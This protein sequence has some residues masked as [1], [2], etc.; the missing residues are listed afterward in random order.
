MED[1]FNAHPG[2]QQLIRKGSPKR[3][4]NSVPI[5]HLR[6]SDTVLFT[7]SV[8]WPKLHREGGSAKPDIFPEVN[9]LSIAYLPSITK[10]HIFTC[11]KHPLPEFRRVGGFASKNVWG[12][13]YIFLINN[14]PPNVA[15]IFNISFYT[16]P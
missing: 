12:V 9:F 4:F 2:F 14:S 11:P 6:E 13:F 1:L 3:Q 16:I 8:D 7:N 5:P 10:F 15:L